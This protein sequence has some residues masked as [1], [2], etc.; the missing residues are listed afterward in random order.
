MKYTAN[1]NLKKPEGSDV[2][3]I[4]D[5][6]INMDI[7]DSEMAKKVDIIVGKGLST[8]DYTTAEKNKL[9]GIATGANNYTHP[10]GTNPH[11]TTKADVGLNSVSNYGVATKAEAEAGSSNA[12]YMTPLRTKESMDAVLKGQQGF[13]K[14]VSIQATAQ[15]NVITKIDLGVKSQFTQ[16]YAK[17][18]TSGM[19]LLDFS[20]NASHAHFDGS[21]GH[22][23][24]DSNEMI[25]FEVGGTGET[26][27]LT[28]RNPAKT[29]T[30]KIVSVGVVY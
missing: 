27:F 5:L 18:P 22:T 21:F 9:T 10:A 24:S 8:N 7:L 20:L 6:N 15:Q 17:G 28:V 29:L 4:D 11:G 25:E 2:V 1:Y 14:I 3:N 12:K 13:A 26:S 19:F 16:V 30:L 23:A